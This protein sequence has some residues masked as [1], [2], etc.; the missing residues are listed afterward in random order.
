RALLTARRELGG[1][2]EDLR[3]QDGVLSFRRDAHRVAVNTTSQ[4]RPSPHSGR[5]VVATHAAAANGDLPGGAAVLL[6]V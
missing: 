6:T 4:A 2:I 1:P 5:V 3:A